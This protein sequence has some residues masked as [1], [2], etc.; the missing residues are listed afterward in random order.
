MLSLSKTIE[1]NKKKYYHELAKAQHSL[2]IDSW[3]H[4]FV[5][6]ILEA[7]TDTE[8]LIDFTLKKVQ[9]FDRFRNQFNERQQR[10]IKRMLEEG[11][12]GFTGGMNAKKYG[13]L[14]KIS[15]ATATRDLQYL[16]K[17]GALKV[18][19]GG[20]STSYAIEL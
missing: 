11:P 1:S 7:Q 2:E 8:N 6:T 3:I 19:G 13:N 17:T 9:F 15:K 18:S 16:L 12:E 14:C 4:Y 10:V 20:R 5:E